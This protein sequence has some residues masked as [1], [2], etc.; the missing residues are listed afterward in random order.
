MLPSMDEFG[1]YSSR[2]RL[3]SVTDLELGNDNLCELLNIDVERL[4]LEIV[5][6]DMKKR[7]KL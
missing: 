1:G 7:Q 6:K 5:K 4:A 2:V 3:G